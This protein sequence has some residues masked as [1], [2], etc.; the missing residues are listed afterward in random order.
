MNEECH[1]E[2]LR[3]RDLSCVPSVRQMLEDLIK[4]QPQLKRQD[5]SIRE[6]I[7]RSKVVNTQEKVCMYRYRINVY[8]NRQKCKLYL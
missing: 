2:L 6:P 3:L 8:V 5:D 7:K 4:N 1:Q